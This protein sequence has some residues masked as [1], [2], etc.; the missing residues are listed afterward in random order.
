MRE[1][2]PVEDVLD[3]L[4]AALRACSN[5]VLIA[6]PGA[7]KTSLVAPALIGQPW[8]SGQI[9]LLSPRRLAARAAAEHMAERAGERPGETIGYMTRLDSKVSARSRI[10]VMTEGVFV[11]RIQSDP[12][13][14]GISAVLFDEVHERSLDMDFGLALALEAQSAFR[15]DLRL[16]AM[17]ATLDGARFAELL[18]G[19]DGSAALIES[20]GQS[21][22]LE[23]RHVGRSAELPIERDMA[24]VI[25]TAL[26][27]QRGD[28]LAFL[29]GLGEI[30]RTADRLDSLAGTIAVHRLHGSVAPA[31]QRAAIRP[32]PEGRRKIILTSA[33][34]ETSLTIDGVRIVVDS[35]LSR[36]A[37]FDPALAISRLVTGRASRASVRQRAGRAA[38]QGPGVAYRLWLEAANGGMAEF[39]PPEILN[40]DLASLVLQCAAWGENDPARLKWLDQPPSA[41]LAEARRRLRALDALDAEGAITPHGRAMADMPLPPELAHMVLAGAAMEQGG[42]A[43]R[44]ALL[45]QERGLGGRSD[46][47]SHRLAR[48]RTDRSE[49]ARA[50]ERLA[51]RWAAMASRA[52]AGEDAGLAPD[53]NAIALL[54]ATA[55]PDRLARRVDPQGEQWQST[56]GRSFRLDPASMLVTADWL[57]VADIQGAAANARIVSA[58]RLDEALVEPHFDGRIERRSVIQFDRASRRARA[59]LEK[60]LGA[61]LLA[62]GPDPAPDPDLVIGC[63]VDALRQHGLALLSPGAKT[64]A[65]RMRARFAGNDALEDAR[66]LET[67]EDWLPALLGD[68]RGFDQIGEAELI[69]AFENL[70]GWDAMREMDRIAPRE[71]VS[72]AGTRHLIDYG[73]EAGPMVELRVQALY[74]LDRH[75]VVGQAQIPLVLSLTSPAGRPIQ[76]T[77][78]LPAF[79]RGSWR[80]VAREMRGRYP[81]HVWPDDPA[82]ARPSLKTRNAQARDDRGA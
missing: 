78:D 70:L 62:S 36:R 52:E 22:D 19:P 45:M 28:L 12:E 13:L 17:S 5:A 61:I 14:A 18:G 49:R 43:S 15:P 67:A 9:L 64:D 41:G 71:F 20:M 10:I 68:R 48:W 16:L 7:G 60:R 74:G 37:E 46:D 75:P 42:L 6:P 81:R 32:D 26:R 51:S 4:T 1:R 65:L 57:A 8:C 3:D 31:D 59:R 30:E 27:E 44:L 72:P 33:I 54:V 47:L 73:A 76:T 82:S 24:N 23:L 25:R 2:L 50:S 56:G 58:A 63:L 66:L 55:F 77:R 35:G 69:Q 29:P 11:N 21:H 38:R 80:D 40:T 79:W 39:D 53:E 34:A